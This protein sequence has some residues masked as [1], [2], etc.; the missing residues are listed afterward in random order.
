[1]RLVVKS[2]SCQVWRCAVDPSVVATAVA[3]VVAV[4]ITVGQ[5][6]SGDQKPFLIH[7]H[8]E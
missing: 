6:G 8:P 4:Q 3:S 5:S 7:K 2:V 1:M